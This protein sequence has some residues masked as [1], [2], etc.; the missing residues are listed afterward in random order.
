MG[1]VKIMNTSTELFLKLGVGGVQHA[2]QGGVTIEEAIFFC[3]LIPLTISVVDAVDDKRR[4][5]PLG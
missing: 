2:L 5:S 4:D 1:L 3:L